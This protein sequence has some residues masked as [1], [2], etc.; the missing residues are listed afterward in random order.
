VVKLLPGS[1]QTAFKA[2]SESRQPEIIDRVAVSDGL[3]GHLQMLEGG[4][5]PFWTFGLGPPVAIDERWA[6]AARAT[7]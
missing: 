6:P 4:A 2:H 1:Y 3:F 7:P 5:Q